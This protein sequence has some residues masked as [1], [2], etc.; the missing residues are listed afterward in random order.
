MGG[1]SLSESKNWHKE[2]LVQK[3]LHSLEK[4]NISNCYVETAED[5]C[6]IIVSLI[7]LGSKV[8]YGRSLTLEQIG[9]MDILRNGKY[10]FFDRDRPK[11]S[12]IEIDKLRR[13][14][15]LA[16]VFLMS[17][18]A[19][20]IKGEIVNIDG[21]GNRL[22][23]L[24]YGPLKVIVVAGINKIVNDKEEAFKRIKNYVA[25]IHAK[26]RGKNLPCTKTGNCVN[27]NDPNRFCNAS[28]VI[29][30]QYLRYK[31]RITVIV[32]GKELGL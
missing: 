27:C 10:K 20:T 9:I 22:A 4:N 8:G 5:A 32:V 12:E 26:R 14:S 30:H 7:P 25:P 17:T 19:L 31:D 18:N 2:I 29:N 3:T 1:N 6:D 23:A 16:D 13:E 15:L 11:L 21:I 28:V 24:I